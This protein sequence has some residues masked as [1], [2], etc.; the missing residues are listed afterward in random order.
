M[1]VDDMILVLILL[2][3]LM[4]PSVDAEVYGTVAGAIKAVHHARDKRKPIIYYMS[5]K[6]ALPDVADKADAYE[7]MMMNSGEDFMKNEPIMII[8]DSCK[9]KKS[10]GY[11]VVEEVIYPVWSPRNDRHVM[12][13]AKISSTQSGPN[14]VGLD[15]KLHPVRK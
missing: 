12:R 6:L 15:G 8:L 13:S 1:V 2:M 4:P 7:G 14:Y 9:K 11:Q 5:W 10:G 3:L